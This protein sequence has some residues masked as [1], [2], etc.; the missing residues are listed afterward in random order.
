MK[1]W[2][3]YK[4]KRDAEQAMWEYLSSN[5]GWM[6]RLAAQPCRDHWSWFGS[7]AC[8]C[9]LPVGHTGIHKCGGIAWGR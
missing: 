2:R 7:N 5:P 8:E 3:E 9:E 6:A 4:R 1:W